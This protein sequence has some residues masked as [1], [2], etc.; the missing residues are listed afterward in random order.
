[1]GIASVDLATTEVESQGNL[2]YEAG[3]YAMKA[4]DGKTLDRGKYCVVWKRTNGQWM[5]HRDIWST[6]MPATT[7]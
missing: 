7:R 5:L 2:A 4:K 3:T 1:M 6:N